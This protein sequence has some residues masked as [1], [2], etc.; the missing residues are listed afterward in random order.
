MTT[1]Q[2]KQPPK[3]YL[4]CAHCEANFRLPI[5]ETVVPIHRYQ[6]G[7]CPGGA[8]LPA[9]NP[10]PLPL[11]V[12]VLMAES[13]G[14][15]TEGPSGWCEGVYATREAA[16]ARMESLKARDRAEGRIVNGDESE[17]DT[18]IDPDDWDKDYAIE[19][20]EVLTVAAP[21][22]VGEL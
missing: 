12:Y 14:E 3:H 5:A 10:K 20:H 8:Q 16:Q 1:K 18:D 4:T 9:P 21:A 2:T 13:N 17:A 19:V 22:K 15:S 11:T 6:T 7:I